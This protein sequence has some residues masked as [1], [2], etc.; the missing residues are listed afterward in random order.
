MRACTK[1][2]ELKPLDQFPPVRRGEPKLQTWCRECFADANARNYQSNRERERARIYRYI[3]KR[4]AEVGQK[5]IDYLREHPCVDCG[6]RDIVVW[7]SITSATRWPMSRPTRGAG[8][9]G[10]A[11]KP[12][13]EKCEVRCA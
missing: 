7:S 2:G 11:S 8:A 12:R 9:R 5:M 4:R 6:E 1:C 10:R 13:Y 3:A